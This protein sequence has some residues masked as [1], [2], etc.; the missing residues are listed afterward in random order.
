MTD[1]F[2]GDSHYGHANIIQ[3]SKRPQYRESDYVIKDGRQ[4]WIAPVVK[5]AR[6]DEMDAFLIARHNSV[7]KPSDTVWHVGDFCFGSTADVIRY[8]RQLNGNFNI[9]YGNHDESL[10]NFASI[11]HLYD[12]LKNRIKF[13]GDYAEINVQGQDIVLM[14]YAMRV[15]NGSHHGVWQL[16]GHSHGSLPDDPHAL[17]FD[18]GLDCHNYYPVSFEQVKAIMA[19]KTFKPIDHHKGSHA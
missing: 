12:D 7:V 4:V 17:S 19:T 3:Y 18:V 11:I 16:Y 8:F 1:F 5:R 9:L 10:R 15:W 2:M 13:L 6:R 14:H